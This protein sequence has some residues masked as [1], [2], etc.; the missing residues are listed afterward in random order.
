MH[1]A[2]I[3]EDKL[4]RDKSLE[5]F[6]RVLRTK[7]ISAFVL[8]RHLKADSLRFLI[9]FSSVAGRFGNRGQADYAAANEVVSKLAVALQ[10]RWPV[11]VCSIAW[12]P[13][14]KLGM[15]SPEL[16]REFARRG[17]ELLSP[18]AGRRALWQ[19]IQQGP[20]AGAEV[21]VGGHV[22]TPLAT[23][24]ELE[25]LPLLKNATREAASVGT[26]RFGRVLDPAVDRFLD[27]HRLD[28]KP[29]LPLAFA[30][31]MMAEAA[32]AAWPD[33]RVVAVR[34]LQLFKGIVVEGEAIPVA[35]TVRAAVHSIGQ[36]THGHR[37]RDLDAWIEAD[38]SVSLGRAIV[39]SFVSSSAVR[40]A[41]VAAG[42]AVEVA[43]RGVSRLD[44]PRSAV[45]AHLARRRYLRR[46][47]AGND[48]FAVRVRPLSRAWAGRSGSSIRS[49]STRRCSCC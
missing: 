10:R 2:G 20:A 25:P 42:T 6:D 29:V 33:L 32:Q 49:C 44:I 18:T 13:W 34:D 37:R 17:V 1:G 23:A 46:R 43:R 35:I 22:A 7:S 12:A 40:A 26:V 15:V 24:V 19:E 21:V 27:D 30:T 4:V 48:L 8:S 41:R 9:F 47:D 31:E 11:R 28:G 14:D 5:S 16:K 3:I 36:R 38:A 39:G 45:P